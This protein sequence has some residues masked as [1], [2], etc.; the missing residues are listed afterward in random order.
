MRANATTLEDASSAPAV[1]A[2][3]AI[4]LGLLGSFLRTGADSLSSKAAF[5]LSA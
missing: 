2:F 4:G 5:V 3:L 1:D